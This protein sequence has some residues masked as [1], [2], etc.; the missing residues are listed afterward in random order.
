MGWYCTSGSLCYGVTAGSWQA[1]FALWLT[2]SLPFAL[3]NI[4]YT[5]TAARELHGREM[6]FDD[7]YQKALPWGLGAA[8]LIF[9]IPLPQ[10]YRWTFERT[11]SLLPALT[12]AAILILFMATIAILLYWLL[13]EV[14]ARRRMH[15]ILNQHYTDPLT[16]Q[17]LTGATVLERHVL[18]VDADGLALSTT[19][20]YRWS[21]FLRLVPFFERLSEDET[22]ARFTAIISALPERAELTVFFHGGLNDFRPN[23]ERSIDRF[24]KMTTRER[25]PLFVLWRSGLLPCYGWH[26][27]HVREGRPLM[28][29]LL[30]IYLVPAKLLADVGRGITRILVTWYYQFITD[31]KPLVPRFNPDESNWKAI[32]SAL[33]EAQNTH[34]DQALRVSLGKDTRAMARWHQLARVFAYFNA[35]TFLFSYLVWF[36]ID[37]LGKS[38]WDVMVRRTRTLF[39][40]V[41]E[42]DLY[43]TDTTS[44]SFNLGYLFSAPQRVL[45]GLRAALGNFRQVTTLSKEMPTIQETGERVSPP[46]AQTLQRR[47]Q[48]IPDETERDLSIAADDLLKT[49]PTGDLYRF[50][51]QLSQ[52]QACYQLTLIGHSMGAIVLNRWL[53]FF[54]N[55][56]YR[57]LV[58]LAAA[59]SIK[60]CASTIIPCLTANQN[61]RFYNLMLHPRAEQSEFHVADFTPRGSLLE[62]IDSYFSLPVTFDDRTAGKWENFLQTTHLFYEVRSRVHIK[63]FGYG[64]HPDNDPNHPTKHGDFT[65][66]TFWEDNF[67]K[68]G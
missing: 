57:S 44:Q 31:L 6:I 17:S 65:N 32:L 3:T 46:R 29:G 18:M 36:L 30:K 14:K 67:W 37:A 2:V 28:R 24:E 68:V 42:F 10:L 9:G 16:Q 54:P 53:E 48:R 59:C 50:V 56:P 43:L 47:V 51:L 5:M 55:L 22:S 7:R 12:N 15:I 58:Y 61:A 49:S 35:W 27:W 41:Y 60:D 8:A 38:A 26:L 63:G 19:P 11:M 64:T 66:C 34:P 13:Y 45:D 25:Y 4:I 62:W 20:V 1:L 52:S 33:S 21:Y 23:L 40:T 39:R